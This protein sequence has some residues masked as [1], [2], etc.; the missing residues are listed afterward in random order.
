MSIY[1]Y[2]IPLAHTNWLRMFFLS[3]RPSSCFI[4]F[5][6]YW[7]SRANTFFH[8]YVISASNDKK[9]GNVIQSELNSMVI[10]SIQPSTVMFL[11]TGM[12]KYSTT[13]AS[14]RYAL[15]QSCKKLKTMLKKKNQKTK[16]H[17][18]SSNDIS[19]T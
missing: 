12:Y 4:M 18:F 6:S 5:L 16:Q 8:M 9:K 10:H 11:Q 3:H 17:K 7:S 15:L 1:G 13:R 19:E 14:Q 2:K